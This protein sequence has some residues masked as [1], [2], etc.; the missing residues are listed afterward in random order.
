MRMDG[1]MHHSLVAER[2]PPSLP[3]PPARRQPP[4]GSGEAARGDNRPQEPLQA[5]LST[6]RRGQTAPC[7]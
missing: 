5:G 1:H 3:I 7:A 6:V 2:S 4:E